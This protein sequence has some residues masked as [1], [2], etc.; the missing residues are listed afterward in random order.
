MPHAMVDASRAC[1]EDSPMA[2]KAK[3]AKGKFGQAL[4]ALEDIGVPQQNSAS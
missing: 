4:Q 3:K 2:K 1:E